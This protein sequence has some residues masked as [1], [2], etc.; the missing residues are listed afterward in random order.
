[1]DDALREKIGREERA[2]K[3]AAADL[4]IAWS[5]IESRMAQLLNQVIHDP[6]IAY[7]IYFAPTSAE[8][9]FKIVDV[10]VDSAFE[11]S[12]RAVKI[13]AL[14]CRFRS[15]L[16]KLKDMR[17]NVAHG[18]IGH[19]GTPRKI[20]VRWTPPKFDI[21]KDRPKN[22]T[23]RFGMLP[24]SGISAHDIV[25]STKSMKKAIH[26]L[27][28]FQDILAAIEPD[29][30]FAVQRII[31]ELERDLPPSAAQSARQPQKAQRPPKPSSASR[32]KV[33]LARRNVSS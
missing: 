28:D 22:K 21:M 3:E 20:H 1:M 10:C 19:I 25:Q 14:W 7:R 5:E 12:E 16:G 32:R 8:T 31:R 23:A 30:D 17:N 29:D 11:N 2:L 26:Q 9:R 24:L 6:E 33:A 27:W 18:S 15:K 13:A 4:F